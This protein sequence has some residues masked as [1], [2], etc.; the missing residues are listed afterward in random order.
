MKHQV[1]HLVAAG[2]T[3]ASCSLTSADLAMPTA[4]DGMDAG[5]PD[6]L[7]PDAGPDVIGSDGDG[8]SDAFERN[9]LDPE[10]RATEPANPDDDGDGLLDGL[11]RGV[12]DVIGLPKHRPESLPTASANRNRNAAL[13]TRRSGSWSPAASFF[14]AT[15]SKRPWTRSDRSLWGSPSPTARR[16]AIVEPFFGQIK[17]ARGFRRFASRRG[18]IAGH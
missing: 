8:L 4:D 1:P 12:R 16:K 9:T 13:Q 17:E 18:P 11:E 6:R 2:I 3:S 7:S 5:P 15:T 10:G 14:G